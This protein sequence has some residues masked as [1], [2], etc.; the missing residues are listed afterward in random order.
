MYTV[1][2]LYMLIEKLTSLHSRKVTVKFYLVVLKI[3]IKFLNLW[4][5][6]AG[7]TW[8]MKQLKYHSFV[9]TQQEKCLKFIVSRC[10]FVWIKIW[11]MNINSLLS[12]PAGRSIYRTRSNNLHL[13]HSLEIHSQILL[14]CKHYLTSFI[15]L[16]WDFR[17][18]IL[19]NVWG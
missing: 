14:E 12:S 6:T 11:L 7:N 13:Q 4:E 19:K 18:I 15:A 2:R 16:N 17:D 3:P 1:R 10:G 9:Q 5:K 8:L